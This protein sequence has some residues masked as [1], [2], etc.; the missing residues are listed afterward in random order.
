MLGAA[1]GKAQKLYADVETNNFLMVKLKVSLNG[2]IEGLLSY[3]DLSM[4]SGKN[5]AIEG[6][7][8]AIDGA[9]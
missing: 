3:Q 9:E 8:L 7:L 1:L 2:I 5:K 6:V 4:E